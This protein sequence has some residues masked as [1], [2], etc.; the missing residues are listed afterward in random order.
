M[1]VTRSL[2]RLACG[3]AACGLA[4]SAGASHHATGFASVAALGL[5]STTGGAG[6]PVVVVDNQDELEFYLRGDSPR[7][8]AVRGSI[9]I[10]NFGEELSVGSNKT[11]LG[12]G[13]DAEIVYGGLNIDNQSN[14]IIRNLTI[15]DSYVEGDWDGKTQDYDGIQV[16]DSHHIWIDHVHVTRMGDGLIDLRGG[17]LD[18]VTISNSILSDHNKALGVGWTDESDQHVTI[19]HTWIRN[20]N[21]RNPSYDN[22]VGHFYNNFLEDISSYG[23]NPRNDAVVVSENN[24]FENVNKP[25]NISGDAELRVSG[26]VLIN[27][28]GAST[29][30]GDAFTPGDF[31]SYTLDDT[32]ELRDL[33][34]ANSGPQAWI[35]VYPLDG[36]YNQDGVVDAA[37]FT[38]WRDRFGDPA[39]A[40][41]NDP[42]TG[43]IGPA[44]HATW[45]ANYGSAAPSLAAAVPEPAAVVSLL[46]G[47]WA[48]LIPRRTGSGT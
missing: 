41:P 38:V 15:R 21:Q 5:S 28:P 12:L 42:N 9:L 6:G 22:V 8:I 39:G 4:A 32:A 27:S 29:P 3:L 36:D 10:D 40:L 31:Y 25:Y 34:R 23:L 35:G 47:S 19:H 20:T 7:T 18:Y 17:G 43:P 46:L 26:D 11:I 44:Q 48:M 14:V 30:R 24:V 37:D 13:A 2:P 45:A 1:S 33:I 16:D